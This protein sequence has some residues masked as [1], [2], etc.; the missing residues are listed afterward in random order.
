MVIGL[1]RPEASDSLPEAA[2]M[3]ALRFVVNCKET[4]EVRPILRP[5]TESVKRFLYDCLRKRRK[6]A[7]RR[8]GNH[9]GLILSQ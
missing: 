8:Q 6:A 1:P 5:F 2:R 9:L 3:Q 4:W 7:S